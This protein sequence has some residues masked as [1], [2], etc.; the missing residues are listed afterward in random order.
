M[1]WHSRLRPMPPLP[2]TGKL[3]SVFASAFSDMSLT[4]Q[5]GD[6][7]ASL[8][9]ELGTETLKMVGGYTLGRVIGEGEPGPVSSR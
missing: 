8:S 9:K 3:R 2:I 5:L 7:Y 4:C 6:A 1:L